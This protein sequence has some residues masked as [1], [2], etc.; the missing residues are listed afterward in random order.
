M[1]TGIMK[2]LFLGII[3]LGII[4]TGFFFFQ[5]RSPKKAPLP[6]RL[7]GSPKKKNGS[8]YLAHFIQPIYTIAFLLSTSGPQAALTACMLCPSLLRLKINLKKK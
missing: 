2:F 1:D 5:S 4:A 7:N 8:M 6:K 3:C